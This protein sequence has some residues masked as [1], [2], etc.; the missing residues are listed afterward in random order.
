MNAFMITNFDISE[1]LKKAKNWKTPESD[2]VHNFCY[3]CITCLH[4]VLAS[5]IHK[6]IEN[7]ELS[8]PPPP[9]PILEETIYML[10]K[11]PENHR[12]VESK[13]HYHSHHCD[14]SCF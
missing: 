1:I 14:F 7:P 11:K 3:K 13:I 8:P 4:L 6:I 5:C 10:S 12:N 9:P 2:I